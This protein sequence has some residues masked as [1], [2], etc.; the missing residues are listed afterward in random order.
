MK[1]LDTAMTVKAKPGYPK[2][3]HAPRILIVGGRCSSENRMIQFLTKL[4]ACGLKYTYAQGLYHG[5]SHKS[6]G[7]FDTVLVDISDDSGIDSRDLS[8]LVDNY[9]R[10]AVIAID[11]EY[12]ERAAKIAHD[13][14]A[15]AYLPHT[16]ATKEAI[17]RLLTD[18]SLYGATAQAPTQVP[19]Y[20]DLTGLATE[21]I[22][23]RTLNNA[24]KQ[25]DLDQV[26]IA[27]FSLAVYDNPSL[28]TMDK[29]SSLRLLPA[30]SHRL[31]HSLRETDLVV[32]RDNANF[33]ILLRHLNT[34]DDTS[35]IAEKL[36]EL[37]QTP[38]DIDG[39][40]LT[41]SCNIGVA[42][43]SLSDKQ[44]SDLISDADAALTTAI[45]LGANHFAYNRLRVKYAEALNLRSRLQTAISHDQFR[46][47]YLPQ[48][49]ITS[50]RIIAVEALLRWQLESGSLLTPAQFMHH[51]EQSRHST[52]VAHWVIENACQQIAE[53]HS[54]GYSALRLSLNLSHK[55]FNDPALAATLQN[56]LIKYG[57][58]PKCLRLEVSE[59]TLR[60]DASRSQETLKQL[61][62]LGIDTIIDD[63]G[64]DMCSLHSLSNFD[65]DE[66]KI[67][68]SLVHS[69]L[70]APTS[71][72][73]VDSVISTCHHLGIS[74]VA[75]AVETADQL[76]Y[77]KNNKCDSYQGL[78]FSAP[79]PADALPPLLIS[80]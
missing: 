52:R 67:D 72:V 1:K 58:E 21:A 54:G 57:A 66:V 50:G 56:A 29:K 18:I 45:A 11:T 43:P 22:L 5:L 4:I 36:I 23:C 12:N 20:D 25:A 44:A 60:R 78:F 27:L 65:I 71:Q 32:R 39:Q 73:M 64:A 34:K 48:V 16:T 77:L 8:I 42:V 3:D 75:E 51:I 69:I 7:S 19:L 49:D 24:L 26:S 63:F 70:N 17:Y 37:L 80:A 6:D 13:H 53:W 76:D 2:P 41:V 30:I 79:L 62:L 47:V 9:T 31:K 61:K 55:Q 46:L 38:F 74:V 14:G 10:C 40:M 28:K 33:G 35:I 15:C 68:M 59:M